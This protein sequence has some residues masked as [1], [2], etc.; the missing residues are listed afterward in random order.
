MDEKIKCAA[1]DCDQM[2][3]PKTKWQRYHATRCKSRMQARR[4]AKT[5]KKLKKQAEAA[6]V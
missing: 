6:H 5:F 4:R 2:F 3:V 1:S